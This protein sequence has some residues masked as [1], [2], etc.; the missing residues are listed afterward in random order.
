MLHI[1][2]CAAMDVGIDWTTISSESLGHQVRIHSFVGREPFT[3]T[4]MYKSS[5]S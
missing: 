3:T 4:T 5:Q 1:E 2:Q